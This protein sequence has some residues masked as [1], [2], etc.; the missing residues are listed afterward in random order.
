MADSTQNKRPDFEKLGAVEYV[1]VPCGPSGSSGKLLAFALIPVAGS[2]CCLF[3]ILAPPDFLAASASVYI[4]LG[5][6]LFTLVFGIIL[7]VL[8]R[9]KSSW[10]AFGFG[11]NTLIFLVSIAWILGATTGVVVFYVFPRQTG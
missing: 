10:R 7:K 8:L 11:R 2:G 6:L 1:P 9:L 4:S 5:G 3:A